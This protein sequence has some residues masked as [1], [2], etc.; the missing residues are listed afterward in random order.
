VGV[1]RPVFMLRWLLAAV[2][3]FWSD[4]LLALAVVAGCGTRVLQWH[5]GGPLGND[6]IAL[7]YSI[8]TLPFDELFGP[9]ILKQG[10]PPGWL[11]AERWIVDEFGHSDRVV[12]V[13]PLLFGCLGVLA[14]ALLARA[15]LSRVGGVVATAL[16]AGAPFAIDYSWQ[17]KP[18]SADM[19]ATAA[20][21]AIGVWVSRRPR[22]SH[23]HGLAFWGTAA[24]AAL[25][26]FPSLFVTAGSAVVLIADRVLRPRTAADG[27]PVRLR[28][29]LA[30]AAG[31][32]VPAAY[33]GGAV[34]ADYQLQLRFLE[35]TQ[36]TH[37]LWV[38]GFGPEHGSLSE[39]ADWSWGA[40]QHFVGVVY[41]ASP[42]WAPLVLAGLGAVVLLWRQPAVA[43]LLTAPFAIALLVAIAQEYPLRQRL[44]LWLLPAL[45]VLLTACLFPSTAIGRPIPTVDLRKRPRWANPRR[46]ARAAE[47]AVAG[48]VIAA[49]ATTVAVP[50]AEPLTAALDPPGGFKHGT[51][52]DPTMSAVDALVRG[53]RDGD[54]VVAVDSQYH[55]VYW[56]GGEQ[57]VPLSIGVSVAPD[58]GCKPDELG[59][60]LKGAK[61][62][63]LVT[64]GLWTVTE[65][66]L[67]DLAVDRLRG[68]G[69]VEQVA[70]DG[71]VRLHLADL[72]KRPQQRWSTATTGP[73]LRA[74]PPP[75]Y[76]D[77]ISAGAPG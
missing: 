56:Y 30:D 23:W 37:P 51:D 21:L 11:A 48:A 4:A 8:R 68:L 9:L 61:R 52:S 35:G 47:A 29:R 71:P 16:F 57:R 25:V 54:R 5:E 34:I 77:D 3:R 62:V 12:R 70:G 60:A 65:P 13:L 17:V 39:K 69:E 10:A 18:Y 66:T 20:L 55:R 31:F 53:Y 6:D 76:L 27:V 32:V 40:L 7:L 19:A 28:S 1:P 43:G 73:C 63:W 44:A 67:P 50:A 38:D 14:V 72:T 33:W 26:S 75:A 42:P 2:R 49:L 46:W 36:N 59:T 74:F 58:G 64:G 22:W 15:A 41:E 24:A 45:V